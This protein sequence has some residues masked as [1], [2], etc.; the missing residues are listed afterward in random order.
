VLQNVVMVKSILPKA[1]EAIITLLIIFPIAFSYGFG[2]G[3]TEKDW[4]DWS[5]KCLL[6]SFDPSTDVKL[7]KWEI[8]LTPGHFIRLRKTYQH[9]KQ[10]YYSLHLNKLDSVNYLGTTTGGQL[11]LKTIADDIIVQTYD[12]PKGNIDSM[13]TVLDIPVKGISPERLDS[14][15]D[16]IKYFKNQ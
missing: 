16:A 14:L 9:G 13:A 12:D 7:K 11:R 2:P 1:K 4:L 10:E 3:M 15:N 6:E 5:N 8:T